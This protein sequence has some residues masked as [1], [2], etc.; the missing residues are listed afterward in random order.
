MHDDSTAT[1]SG[2]SPC[3]TFQLRAYQAE[4][5]EE[6]MRA[7]IIVVMD[8]GSGKTQIAIERT[9]AELETCQPD[10]P[11][12]KI[13]W[14]LAPTVSLCEQQHEVFMSNL[15]GFGHQILCGRDD[16][17][18]WTTQ[19]QWDSILTNVRIV[20]STHQ[21]LFEA[22]THGFVTLTKLALL[23]F[24]EAHHCTLNHPAN[25]LMTKFYMPQLHCNSTSLPKVLGLTASPVMKAVATRQGLE[26]IEQNLY[27]TAKTPKLHR[28][29]LMRYVHQPELVQIAYPSAP[30]G[31]HHSQLL[32]A[33]QDAYQTYDLQKDP[34]LIALLDQHSKG[35]DVSR[36]LDRLW[37]SRKT[38]C[39]DQLKQLK[40]KAEAMADELGTS[41]MEFY[42]RQCI[43]TFENMTGI[44]DQQL[45]DLSTNERQ[46]LLNPPLNNPTSVPDGIL[47][48][49]SQ[50][51][52]ILVDTLVA[53]VEGNPDFTGLVFV[54]QRVWVASLAEILTCHPRTKH[55]L[56][57]GTFVGTS[58][59]SKRKSNISVFAE[60]KNQQTTLD[61]F[62]A[63]IINLVLATSVLE[64]G[65]DVSSCHLVICFEQPKNLKS[66]VQRRGRA[67]RQ[68]SRY[69][70]FV[71]D[72]RNVQSV[73]SWQ[74]LEAE[75]RKAYED[76]NRKVRL[77]QEKE[78]VDE[79]GERYLRI[80]STG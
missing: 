36:Q 73:K 13:V 78:Q 76:D 59:S 45:L 44:F 22:L 79:Y 56:R 37:S 38:Y 16:I 8:T 69:L 21:V 30:P 40:N 43:A 53:E 72:T 39:Y 35:Y 27:A 29:E 57:V 55:L 80:E 34:Y 71:P 26:L 64:E 48:N 12:R 41:V 28:S 77:A 9:R 25:Q 46:H 51:V 15:P 5:V 70:V 20:V 3:E 2:A 65:I 14:F 66:F 23:I 19:R 6:S 47:D 4:M 42:L 63:G 32:L 52:N 1:A 74:S 54:E 11:T 68:R 31:T 33:L 75:M 58:K 67:R 49:L 17:E 62:R 50:K 24:D 18:F 7:N 61:D 10:K 60:P